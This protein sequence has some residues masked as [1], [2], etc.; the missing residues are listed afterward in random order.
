MSYFLLFWL[1]RPRMGIAMGYSN[2]RSED[3]NE[4]SVVFFPTSYMESSKII[5]F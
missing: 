3:L 4:L 5:E 2:S 1:D